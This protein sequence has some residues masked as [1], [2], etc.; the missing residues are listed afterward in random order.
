MSIID[1]TQVMEAWEFVEQIRWCRRALAAG[2]RDGWSQV[3]LD[4][5]RGEMELAQKR[6][7]EV[8]K[9]RLV[10]DSSRRPEV[11]ESKDVAREAAWQYLEVTLP[12]PGD[13]GLGILF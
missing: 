12:E 13:E 4:G 8:G 9:V 11:K 10:L 2:D 3:D 5:I 1:T 6:L 7:K